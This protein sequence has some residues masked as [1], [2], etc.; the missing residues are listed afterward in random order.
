MSEQQGHW[1][2]QR[3]KRVEALRRRR[4]AGS[5]V[6]PRSESW[7]QVHITTVL[8]F[9]AARRDGMV[10]SEDEF[11]RFLDE[12]VTPRFPDGYSVARALGRW[13]S[14]GCT[15]RESSWTVS[16]VRN[17]RE[18]AKQRID[19]IGRIYCRMFDQDAVLRTD[20]PSNMLFLTDSD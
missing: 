12:V 7:H 13:R 4:S 5:S 19:E 3:A 16:I 1:R 9:G 10:V 18:D 14:A 11:E 20:T 8:Y 6:V 17:V 2:T 15:Y